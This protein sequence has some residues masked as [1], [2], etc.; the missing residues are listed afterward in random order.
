MI[1]GDALDRKA[2]RVGDCSH[3]WIASFV[4]R[5]GQVKVALRLT[6]FGNGACVLLES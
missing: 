5:P 2:R 1:E 3:A 4:C 6:H